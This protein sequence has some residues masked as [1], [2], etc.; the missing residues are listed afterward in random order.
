VGRAA[1]AAAIKKKSRENLG[2]GQIHPAGQ[3]AIQFEELAHDVL[4][5]SDFK[6]YLAA[7]LNSENLLFWE[8]VHKFKTYFDEKY[9]IADLQER[10]RMDESS[11]H[12]FYL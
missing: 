4:L 1:R 12:C 7:R 10:E 8:D 2:T 9:V 6:S 3:R 5:F 11:R